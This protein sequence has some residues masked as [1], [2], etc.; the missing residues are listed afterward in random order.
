MF[1]LGKLLFN[2]LIIII[3]P[4]MQ[5]RK[6]VTPKTCAKKFT[7][8]CDLNKDGEI[9]VREWITCL[10]IDISSKFIFPE[11]FSINY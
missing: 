7:K 8:Y 11:V 9:S 3:I 2:I 1:N 5:F 10:G 4:F 6:H